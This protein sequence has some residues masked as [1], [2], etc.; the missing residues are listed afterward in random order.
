MSEVFAFATSMVDGCDDI[1][2][3]DGTHHYHLT[4]Y[5]EYER[6]PVISS[7]VACNGSCRS[8]ELSGKLRDQLQ[9]L[10]DQVFYDGTRVYKNRVSVS[11]QVKNMIT[12]ESLRGRIVHSWYV[13][14]SS[15]GEVYA[16]DNGLFVMMDVAMSV[17]E[18][19]LVRVEVLPDDHD[20]ASTGVHPDTATNIPALFAAAM[21]WQQRMNAEA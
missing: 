15:R 21:E 10:R 17:G 6:S 19:S 1:E 13:K 5:D 4:E 14:R 3:C 16:L 8:Q 11:R 2:V 20:Y 12:T 7:P 18:G 9:E